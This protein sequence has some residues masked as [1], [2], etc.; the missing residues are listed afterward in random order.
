MKRIKDRFDGWKLL[1]NELLKERRMQMK[2]PFHKKKVM[3]KSLHR[4]PNLIKKY[5]DGTK[6]PSLSTFKKICL[7]LQKSADELLGLEE[8]ENKKNSKSD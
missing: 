8:V 1:D 6:I 7:Y 4:D 3:A 5:E 2:P